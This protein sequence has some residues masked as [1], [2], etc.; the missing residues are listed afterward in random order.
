MKKLTIVAA[1]LVTGLALPLAAQTADETTTAAEQLGLS[2]GTP[3]VGATYVREE[4]TDWELRCVSA[5]EGQP[6]PCQLYQLLLDIDGNAVAE[7]NLFDVP[8]EGDLVAGATIVT[9]LDTLLTGQL[10]MAVDNS[11]PR[12]YPFSFCQAVGCFVRLGLTSD[13]LHAFEGGNV[14]TVAIVPLPAPDQVV[15]LGLSLSGF[16]A[17]FAALEAYNAEARLQIEALIAAQEGA[18]PASE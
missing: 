3:E 15:A 2:T 11:Q 1:L 18:E 13:D 7:F 9:P 4:F 14:A 5:P 16:T 6:D 12:V 17:G 10:R 8:D